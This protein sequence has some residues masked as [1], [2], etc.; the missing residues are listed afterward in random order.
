MHIF[1]RQGSIFKS[2]M[3]A[4]AAEL[5]ARVQE[6]SFLVVGGAGTI[7]QAVV[8]EIFARSPRV[9]HVVDLS[10]NN[11]VELVRDLRSSNGYIDGDFRTFCLDSNSDIFEAFFCRQRSL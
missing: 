10:E 11:L 2:D 7:G 8:R 6:A 1:D 3:D 5:A 4:L 9:L